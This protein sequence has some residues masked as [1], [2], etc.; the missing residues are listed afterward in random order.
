M[1]CHLSPPAVPW[2]AASLFSVV[3]FTSSRLIFPLFYET[4]KQYE[5]NLEDSLQESSKTWSSDKVMLVRP[6]MFFFSLR[7]HMMP[8]SKSTIT[9]GRAIGNIMF[10]G[11]SPS[12]YI[13]PTCSINMLY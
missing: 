3:D 5:V 12:I 4:P 7:Y 13:W 1:G 11:S 2:I 8:P 9:K 6:A 10:E